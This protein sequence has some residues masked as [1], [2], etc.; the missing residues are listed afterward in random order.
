MGI[1]FS[2]KKSKR[3]C[4]A[5][6]PTQNPPASKPLP[7]RPAG[8]AATPPRA[9]QQQAQA[10]TVPGKKQIFIAVPSKEKKAQLKGTDEQAATGAAAAVAAHT[11][12]AEKTKS[13]A[14]TAATKH[15]NGLASP[16]DEDS[17][18]ASTVRTSSC[19][20]EEVESILIQCGRLSRNSSAVEA[21][22]HRS[23]KRSYDFDCTDRSVEEDREKPQL[24]RA[25]PQRHRRTLSRD[26]E[27]GE[28]K[29]PGSRERGS[30]GNGGRR[31]SRSPGR[32]SE[33]VVASSSQASSA[34]EKSRQTP[35]KMVSVPARE[36]PSV[37]SEAGGGGMGSRKPPPPFSL[38][39][40]GNKRGGEMRSGSPRS[41]SPGN[42]SRSCNENTHSLSR[43]SSRKAEQ[44]PYRRNPMSEVDGN[45]VL[46]V[47]QPPSLKA[48]QMSH[49]DNN[50]AHN[51]RKSEEGMRKPT[52]SNHVQKI[53]ENSAPLRRNAVVEV[54]NVV[55]S[56]ST[57][58]SNS[59]CV[60]EQ[61][62]SCRAKEQLQRASEEREEMPRM[63]PKGGEVE[64]PPNPR[65]ITRSRSSRRSSRDLDANPDDLLNQTS[66]TSLLLE[67]IQNYHQQT[68]AFS[69]PACVSKACS[70]LEAVADL[71]SSFGSKISETDRS[72]VD[73][74]H[75]HSVKTGKL[76]PTQDEFVEAEAVVKDDL[77]RPSL[78]K[79][80]S[81]RD[82]GED[83]EPQ[84][85]AG[86]NS[87]VG[88]SWASP[89]EPNSAESADRCWTSSWSNNGAEEIGEEF[90]PREAQKQQ[91]HQKQPLETSER[92][93][94]KGAA[95][96]NQN[97]SAAA[98][99]GSKRTTESR[100]RHQQPGRGASSSSSSSGIGG[101]AKVA[102]GVV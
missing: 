16:Q 21:G 5:T 33:S 62:L 38:A 31:V 53:G 95:A 14:P 73:E 79:Y 61:L 52:T 30:G 63:V 8:A 7:H 49:N 28:Q 47:D 89:C 43:S 85:S 72:R 51:N 36:K 40:G 68:A 18:N 84:E 15:R 78:H 44:S 75:Y 91:H 46:K 64:V 4:S 77:M 60:R 13:A 87:Y 57:T 58:S 100:S 27:S 101:S 23:R 19:T 42:P 59:R 99:S 3:L 96:N 6:T 92:R 94:R 102:V 1:C 86:S 76:G 65:V 2:K 20:K 70:I 97:P 26:R 10:A 41:R 66:Y 83:L 25:S 50:K 88:Q 17:G 29:R 11:T 67:D 9:Q 98:T 24:N 74:G 54:M 82:L 93:L 22:Y 37:S 34:L 71:N 32:R 12:D 56:S 35:G 39:D 48:D 55:N 80:V 69:L 90:G 45:I 81:S